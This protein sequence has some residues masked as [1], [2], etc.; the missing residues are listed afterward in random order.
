LITGITELLA[1][2]RERTGRD[3][4]WGAQ[5]ER[6]LTVEDCFNASDAM[7]A[8]VSAVISDYLASGK[9]FAVV[10]VG[11]SEEQL[12]AEAPAAAAGYPIAEDLSDLE[13]VLERLLV[14]DPAVED[15]ARMRRYYLGDHEPGHAADGFLDAAREL[16]VERARV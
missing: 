11:R 2:D 9:P 14:S 1:A 3:H 15:R 16:L 12:I 4:L 7:I 6:E 8:D 13:S 5:A 10:S